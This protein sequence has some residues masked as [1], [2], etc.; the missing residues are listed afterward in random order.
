M[1]INNTIFHPKIKKTSA[2]IERENLALN[3]PVNSHY[4]KDKGS[5]FDVR[6]PED[7]KIDHVADRMGHPEILLKPYE[8]LLRIDTLLAHPTNLDQPFIKIPTAHPKESVDFSKGDVIY[9]N[10]IA[11]DYQKLTQ[12]SLFLWNSYLA[13]WYVNWNLFG[14]NSPPVNSMKDFMLH[15]Q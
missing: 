2:E 7:Q 15:L 5:K 8:S 13:F 12:Y 14:S 6:V 10:Q 11:M 9:D 4:N 3:S 1:D